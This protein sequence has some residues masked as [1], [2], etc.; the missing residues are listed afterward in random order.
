MH[1]TLNLKAFLP[2]PGKDLDDHRQATAL[3]IGF[4]QFANMWMVQILTPAMHLID[5]MPSSTDLTPL[6]S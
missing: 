4:H 3:L 2:M 1:P 6:P 5:L